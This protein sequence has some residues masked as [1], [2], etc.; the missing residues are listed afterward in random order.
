[1]VSPEP[2]RAPC[3]GS[4]ILTTAIND[5]NGTASLDLAMSVAE[6]FEPEKDKAKTIAA[7]VGK[8][9]ST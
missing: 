1:M 6:Y 4:R 3:P 5:D 7:R 9:V 2:S 8:A